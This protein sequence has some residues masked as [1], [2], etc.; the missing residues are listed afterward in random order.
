LRLKAH[1][2]LKVRPG[3]KQ[4]AFTGRLGDAWKLDVS[5]PP[6]DGKA[7]EEIIRF[8]AKLFG[9]PRSA[10][11]IVSGRD[12]ARKL[13]EIVGI[14]SGTLARVILESHGSRPHTGSASKRKS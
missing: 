6:V 4:A 12:S 3:A 13:I 9:T 8:L 11:R 7:N 14:D 10:V 2:Q 1:I 5:S